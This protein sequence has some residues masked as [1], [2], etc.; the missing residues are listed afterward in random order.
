M[1]QLI[2]TTKLSPDNIKNSLINFFNPKMKL[3]LKGSKGKSIGNDEPLTLNDKMTS[4]SIR[5][6]YI[7]KRTK[8]ASTV[9]AQA[10][11]PGVQ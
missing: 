1:A 11:D 9:D 8:A 5:P 2:Q 6:N 3:L 10:V 7:P 4:S